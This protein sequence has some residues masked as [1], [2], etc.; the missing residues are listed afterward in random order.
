MGKGRQRVADSKTRLQAGDENASQRVSASVR[1]ATRNGRR[2]DSELY[3]TNTQSST[4]R[5]RKRKRAAVDELLNS[6][7]PPVKRKKKKDDKD[8]KRRKRKAPNKAAAANTSSTHRHPNENVARLTSEELNSALEGI[9]P[10]STDPDPDLQITHTKVIKHEAAARNTL[11][12]NP[13]LQAKGQTEE[14]AID[15]ENLDSVD[16]LA[17]E[18]PARPSRDASRIS[19]SLRVSRKPLQPI[20]NGANP[21]KVAN[22]AAAH[23]A[24]Q[25]RA[26]KWY[27][28][29]GELHRTEVPYQT[30]RWQAP[31]VWE[32]SEAKAGRNCS[33]DGNKENARQQGRR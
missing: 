12:P 29:A 20:N 30:R 14:L 2:D 16:E 23:T 7:E 19:L 22:L 4:P 1:A 15:V 24:Q 8:K 9:N 18:E 11:Q 25:P 28:P 31:H 21:Q 33:S 17:V 32:F 26:A 10:D 27:T 13:A 5:L 3:T 6:A